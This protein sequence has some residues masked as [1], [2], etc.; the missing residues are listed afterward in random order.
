ME[1][2]FSEEM[3]AFIDLRATTVA[4][5]HRSSCDTQHPIATTRHN[6]AK[7]THGKEPRERTETAAWLG[8]LL[9][10]FFERKSVCVGKS[11]CNLNSTP[12]SI[13]LRLREQTS[14]DV[15]VS[16]KF[17]LY[18]SKY[19]QGGFR[20][21]R[22]GASRQVSVPVNQGYQIHSKRVHRTIK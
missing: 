22:P 21:Y 1:V 14:S 9:R 10:T 7:L 4:R 11:L 15:A 5:V 16:R 19:V 17:S 12:R 20:N 18:S 3:W 13:W 2:L 6:E 8:S